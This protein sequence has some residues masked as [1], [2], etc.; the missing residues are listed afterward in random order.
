MWDIPRETHRY[1][2]E[3]ISEQKHVRFIL[4]KRFLKF[5]KQI[6]NSSKLAIKSLLKICKNDCRSI[7]GKNLRRLMLMCDKDNI[8]HLKESDIDGLEYSPIPETETWRM[9]LLPELLSTRSS[10]TEIP[11]FTDKEITDLVCLVCT[12]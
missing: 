7:T 3:P 11:G 8:D 1:F 10:N 12:S 2:L 6:E 9:N 4:Y 5:I